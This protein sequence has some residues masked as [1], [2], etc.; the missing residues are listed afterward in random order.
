MLFKSVE[1]VWLS[2]CDRGR[3]DWGDHSHWTSQHTITHSWTCC[4][5]DVWTEIKDLHPFCHGRVG[6]RDVNTPQQWFPLDKSRIPLEREETK[7]EWRASRNMPRSPARS[8]SRAGE[9]QALDWRCVALC[10]GC[11]GVCLNKSKHR[12]TFGKQQ[13]TLISPPPSLSLSCSN[14]CSQTLSS[15][16]PHQTAPAPFLHVSFIVFNSYLSIS[17]SASSPAFTSPTEQ[18]HM[19]IV[20]LPALAAHTLTAVL[21]KGIWNRSTWLHCSFIQ[22]L[23]WS[24]ATARSEFLLAPTS[25]YKRAVITLTPLPLLFITC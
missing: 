5:I 8:F 15:H 19:H 6:L 1:S 2:S 16:L 22:L 21:E 13:D 3:K 14:F 20:Q 25:L 7:E 11:L 23:L 4:I 9:L 10:R 17:V 24:S 12:R 18:Q